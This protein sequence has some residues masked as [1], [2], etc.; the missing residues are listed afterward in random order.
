M[1]YHDAKIEARR[2][3]EIAHELK[4]REVWVAAWTATAQ[5]NN[6][7]SKDVATSWADECLKQ[8]DK[9]FK[10]DI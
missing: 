10:F 5:A 8:Y 2:K 7:A 1:S 4:R 3:A 6:C 9:R